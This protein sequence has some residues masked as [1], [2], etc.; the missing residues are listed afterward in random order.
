MVKLDEKTRVSLQFNNF[1]AI[2]VSIVTFAVV[3]SGWY[4]SINNRLE[5]IENLLTKMNKNFEGIHKDVV[6]NHDDILVMK[7]VLSLN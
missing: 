7:Q 1:Y 3:V 2:L 5:N 6:M 4:T